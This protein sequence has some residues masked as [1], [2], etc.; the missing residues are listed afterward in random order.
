MNRLQ[1]LLEKEAEAAYSLFKNHLPVFSSSYFCWRQR[2]CNI[3]LGE[4]SYG[5]W[6]QVPRRELLPTTATLVTRNNAACVSV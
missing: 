3:L 2:L 6:P 1:L 4:W 5:C